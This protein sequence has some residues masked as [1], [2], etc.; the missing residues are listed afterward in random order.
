[1]PLARPGA[2]CSRP[3]AACARAAARGG[4]DRRRLPQPGLADPFGAA[5]PTWRSSVEP[6]S[7]SAPPLDATR[8]RAR[9]SPASAV[10]PARR[11]ARGRRLD[12]RRACDARARRS[13]GRRTVVVAE[14]ADGRTRPSGR[15]GTRR[16][17]SGSTCR[18]LFRRPRPLAEVTRWTLAAAV[19]GGEACR[20]ACGVERDDQV[21]E[22]PGRWNGRKLGGILCR[23]AHRSRGIERAR[24]RQRASTCST[25]TGTSRPSWR[26]ARPR[27][28]SRAGASMLDREA[29]ARRLP[30]APGPRS[31]PRTA[32]R[33]DW[34]AVG[35][36]LAR[37][38][39]AGDR[40]VRCACRPRAPAESSDGI[41]GRASTTRGALRRAGHGREPDARPRRATPFAS[42]RGV[43]RDAA[44]RRRR[45]H[46]HGLRSVRGRAARG[47]TGASRRATMPRR[48]SSACSCARSSPTPASVAAQV[49][50]HDRRLGRARP[51]RG[52]RPDRP[53]ATS[54]RAAVR[55]P[56]DQDR[57]ADPLREPARGRRRSDRQRG[58]RARR[59]TARR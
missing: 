56:G 29:L 15:A 58:G 46:A 45:Q 43:K 36:S 26:G 3:R 9:C 8:L 16:Q 10:D 33:D 53:G 7:L 20:E 54:A 48:T 49:D 25:A 2:S 23:A 42:T 31:W 13:A 55:R 51:Q 4:R 22:R 38:R 35:A 21:A 34:D 6:R 40:R 52:V 30:G 19:A 59:A 1:M 39:A 37:A 14:R 47:A 24:R 11:R 57:D 50:G 44:R 32:T 18:S 17:G 5:R 28:R 41:D 27:S 12:E